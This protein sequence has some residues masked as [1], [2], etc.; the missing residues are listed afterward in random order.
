MAELQVEGWVGLNHFSL[1]SIG[2]RVFWAMGAAGRGLGGD[3]APAFDGL[4]G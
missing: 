1:K 2:T 3:E 4:E